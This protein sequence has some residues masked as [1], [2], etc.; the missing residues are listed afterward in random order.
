MQG[1]AA[2][3]TG[4]GMLRVFDTD[5]SDATRATDAVATV[6][7]S[8]TSANLG[9][10][11][12]A[13]DFN[14]DGIVDISVGVDSG[15]SFRGGVSTFFGPFSGRFTEL[16]ADHILIGESSNSA[17]GFSMDV[18]GDTDGDGDV[19]LLVGAMGLGRGGAY[20]VPGGFAEGTHLLADAPVKIRGD[21][22]VSQF[23]ADLGPAGDLDGDGRE[24]IVM[25]EGYFSSNDV[26][27]F[28]GLP[29]AGALY[30]TDALSR[31]IA[32]DDTDLD[33]RYLRSPGDVTGDG[34]DDVVAGSILY[35]D[36]SG[37]IGRLYIIP[38]FGE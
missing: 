28:A 10:E 8:F 31:W 5:L 1:T 33:Y 27:L 4:A 38:G 15:W 6:Y 3:N 36:P 14:G 29:P 34:L 23:G 37:T 11:H 9:H 17:A 25:A 16:D 2:G 32:S 18:G 13:A 30:P 19:D 12:A 35:E 21:S 24:D 20:V 22:S 26:L 7:G